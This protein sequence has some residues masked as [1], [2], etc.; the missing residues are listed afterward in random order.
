MQR[1]DAKLWRSASWWWEDLLFTSALLKSYSADEREEWGVEEENQEI[2]ICRME[3]LSDV[4]IVPI[5]HTTETHRERLLVAAAEGEHEGWVSWEKT[6]EA[7]DKK[8]F[9]RSSAYT[10][11]RWGEKDGYL[12]LLGSEARSTSSIK[13]GVSLKREH[14]WTAQNVLLESCCMS[15]MTAGGSNP[16][17]YFLIQDTP[18]TLAWQH[19]SAHYKGPIAW[20]YFL[21]GKGDSKA[22]HAF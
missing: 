9:F 8:N 19:C 12:K 20:E 7:V 5:A 11:K 13:P 10:K 22:D 16:T 18:K 6:L 1:G 21:P 3:D 2:L 14:I 15:R 4:V 17:P